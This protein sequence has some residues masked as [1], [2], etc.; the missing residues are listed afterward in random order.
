MSDLDED[1]VPNLWEYELR[2]RGKSPDN[3]YD[4]YGFDLTV[5][6]NWDANETY[7]EWLEYGMRRTSSLFFDTTE[8]YF[9]I[10]RITIY[11]NSVSW[12]TS[13]IRIH[14]GDTQRPETTIIGPRYINMPEC[15]RIDNI[16]C[17]PFSIDTSSYY[18]SFA[19]AHELGHYKLQ[20]WD[21]YRSPTIV[22]D[23]PEDYRVHSIMASLFGYK[24]LSTE[25][26]YEEC[27]QRLVN[28][29]L[30]SY[31]IERLLHTEQIVLGVGPCWQTV[32]SCWNY[33][34]G[35]LITKQEVER[36]V[37]FDLDHNKITDIIYLTGYLHDEFDSYTAYVTRDYYE[38]IE[39]PV[40]CYLAVILI[41]S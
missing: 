1:I 32:F 7:M 40:G 39:Y 5:S 20:L 21:E 14:K 2:N 25:E 11:D 33:L 4:T 41:N 23:I 13:D 15:Y 19:L 28:A 18:W 12:F 10:R 22:G 38:S 24:E 37:Q 27:R 9:L 8:G 30:G 29:G 16:I 34:G 31:E 6:L 17:Y 36:G 35:C 3:P 26:D